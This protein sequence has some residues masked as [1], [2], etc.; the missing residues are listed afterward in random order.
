MNEKQLYSTSKIMTEVSDISNR[1]QVAIDDCQTMID[2]YDREK[3]NPRI[4]FY[5]FQ[6][7]A[8][9]FSAMTPIFILWDA[10][11]KA[12]QALPAA[13]VSIA[14][15]LNAV[16][17]WR[18]NWALRAY[19]AEAL[20]RELM[21][22]RAR[23]SQKYNQNLNEQEALDNFVDTINTLTMNEVTEWKNIQTQISETQKGLNK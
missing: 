6:I 8:V 9:V 23:A 4:L 19:T 17:K 16:F 10:L 18:E 3:K 14:V 2:W 12:I 1:K 7:I 21:K 5:S 11:P 13:L 15:A 22:Y 20:K